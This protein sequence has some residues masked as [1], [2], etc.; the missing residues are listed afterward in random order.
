MDNGVMVSVLVA[1]YNPKWPELKRTLNSVLAQQ[2]VD[3]EIVICDDGSAD[4]KEEQ[5]REYFN[6]RGFSSYIIDIA[7]ANGG[8][9]AAV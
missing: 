6:E 4:N 5:I 3:L 2:G 7:E 8:I 9:S 1:T